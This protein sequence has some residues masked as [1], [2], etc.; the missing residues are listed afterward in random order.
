VSKQG[1]PLLFCCALAVLLHLSFAGRYGFF[2]DELYFIACGQHPS[3]GYVDQPPLLP[4]LAAGWD[5]LVGGSL[6]GFRVLPALSAGCLAALTGLLARRFG[7]G[8][9]A[10]LLAAVAVTIGP[11]FLVSAHLFTV[12]MLEPILWTWIV[13]VLDE[14]R[15]RA[16]A[17]RW[18]TLGVLMGLG[19]LNK[20]SIAF[21]GVALALGLLL[22]KT[23]SLLFSRGAV[24]GMALALA[25]VLPS[26]WW[27]AQRGW[28][29]LE[30]LAAGRAGKNVPFDG[31]GFL[32]EVALQVHPITAPLWLAGLWW[33]WRTR[34]ALAIAALLFFVA[35][36][37]LKAK[38]YY[39]A[40]AFPSLLAAGAVAVEGVLRRARWRL[41]LA[42]TSMLLTG[43]V[44]APLVVPILPVETLLRYQRSLGFAPPPLENREYGELAQHLADQ[45]GWREI[46]AAAAL[47]WQSLA[48]EDQA[49]AA[50]FTFNY[51]DAAAITRFGKVPAISGHNHYAELGPEPA[52]GSVLIVFGS[53]PEELSRFYRS[54]ERIGT[55]P[56]SPYMMP[57]ERARP[58]WLVREPKLPL[59]DMWRL[60]RHID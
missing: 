27:Q 18:V 54:I 22:G 5:Q 50:V 33:L 48:T 60:M 1:R 30:L 17:R 36:F 46:G 14:Q 41:A 56:S 4:L 13:L 10:M 12:N 31:L 49:R 11:V 23:R 58:I 21:W 28:P 43:A 35:M 37:A 57:Y 16:T 47:A 52:D 45:F 19:L 7:G 53:S 8:S 29:F 40:P 39:L 6:F 26:T 25:L 20:Y 9:A 55:G 2:R 24:A 32:T 42:H 51:G 15:E 38:P 34:R 59:P 44:T 3:W